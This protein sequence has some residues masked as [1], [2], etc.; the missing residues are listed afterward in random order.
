MYIYIYVYIYS[1]CIRMSFRKIVGLFGS[2]F[3]PSVHRCQATRVSKRFVHRTSPW[4]LKSFTLAGSTYSS[5]GILRSCAYGILWHWHL[6]A[7]PWRSLCV[8]ASFTWSD[9]TKNRGIWRAKKNWYN[10]FQDKLETRQRQHLDV[11]CA[12]L[13]T[14]HSHVAVIILVELQ[15]QRR[16]AAE[17]SA[18]KHSSD[19][20]QRNVRKLMAEEPQ[21]KPAVLMVS[22][23]RILCEVP[24]PG[25]NL[26]G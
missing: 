20:L 18:E 9:G 21:K 15:H 5:W 17:P 26:S 8:F 19:R 13:C 10:A 11:P 6:H 23:N 1:E 24:V 12:S 3:R 7:L 14:L 22:K 4:S 16:L 2:K 25:F